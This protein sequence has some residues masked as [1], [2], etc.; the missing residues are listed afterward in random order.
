MAYDDRDL[1]RR[2]DGNTESDGKDM[3]MV[4]LV[5]ERRPAD[6]LSDNGMQLSVPDNF[7]VYSLDQ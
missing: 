4:L 7:A 3:R 1:P 6:T 2:L 5:K